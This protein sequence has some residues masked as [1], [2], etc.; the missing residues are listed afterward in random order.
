G[1]ESGN[2]RRVGGGGP[3]GPY[4]QSPDRPKRRPDRTV[5]AATPPDLGGRGRLRTPPA[6]CRVG[7]RTTPGGQRG[8]DRS[9]TGGS[10]STYPTTSMLSKPHT[11]P[12][13]LTPLTLAS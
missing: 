3:V 8:P 11:A 7:A 9:P 4:R 6:H 1:C 10:E 5:G 13:D 2:A 12:A